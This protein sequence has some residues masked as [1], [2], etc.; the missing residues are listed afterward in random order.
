MITKEKILAQLQQLPDEFSLEEFIERL[1]FI[2]KLEERI[3]ES[4]ADHTIDEELV[5]KEIEGWFK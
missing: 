1:I 3:K 4:E 2:E 5:N